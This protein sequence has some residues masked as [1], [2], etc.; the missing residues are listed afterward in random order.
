MC[1]E[2]W[3]QRLPAI[4]LYESTGDAAFR[5][6]SKQIMRGA[7]RPLGIRERKRYAVSW[8]PPPPRQ[9]LLKYNL[10]AMTLLQ[11]GGLHCKCRG[12]ALQSHRKFAVLT[13]A[14]T[15]ADHVMTR[16]PVLNVDK[17]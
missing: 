15:A 14:S 7:E 17:F 4:M 8:P 3:Q 13:D 11:P 2:N 6:K 1:L 9:R 5:D 10:T 16:Y 12:I